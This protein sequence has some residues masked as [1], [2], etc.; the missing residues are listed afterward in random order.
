MLPLTSPRR[1]EARW[2]CLRLF[3]CHFTQSWTISRLNGSPYTAAGSAQTP[4]VAPSSA[5]KSASTQ[6]FS[7]SPSRSQ[8]LRGGG[9]GGRRRLGE[10]QV[11]RCGREEARVERRGASRRR[12]RAR[13]RRAPGAA[14]WWSLRAVKVAKG[15]RSDGVRCSSRCAVQ[16]WSRMAVGARAAPTQR[17]MLRLWSSWSW[18][19]SVL[20]YASCR[21]RARGAKT[22]CCKLPVD[23]PGSSSQP[24]AS[25]AA[26]KDAAPFPVQI[27]IS[28]PTPPASLDGG[29]RGY[30][31][32]TMAKK[33]KSQ[34]QGGKSTKEAK[35]R[36]RAK[37]KKHALRSATYAVKKLIDSA[38]AEGQPQN[39]VD[40]EAQQRRK[41]KSIRRAAAATARLVEA[42]VAEDVEGVRRR[43]H[44]TN[45]M[46]D[47]SDSDESDEAQ[48]AAA[49]LAPFVGRG[50]AG[51]IDETAA[52]TRDEARSL[53]LLEGARLNAEDS[54]DAAPTYLRTRFLPAGRRVRG[55]I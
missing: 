20:Q 24:E 15:R 1:F 39:A 49:A 9:A 55:R 47:E 44:E 14:S 6:T 21:P 37:S 43:S 11:G 50:L 27:R 54:D 10:R 4:F 52:T 36:S 13:R 32:K 5:K 41:K 19:A 42:A 22:R 48:D 3:R 25:D 31:Y 33:R 38:L 26:S 12:E 53:A 51:S 7:V 16:Q 17:V 30:E 34:G 45:Q 8:F 23:P 28:V 46:E 18:L 2:I 35:K 29:R 40:P